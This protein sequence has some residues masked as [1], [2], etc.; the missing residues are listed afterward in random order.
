MPLSRET[1]AMRRIDTIEGVLPVTTRMVVAGL[2]AAAA[3]EAPT[4]PIVVQA[5]AVPFNVAGTLNW[6]GDTYEIE[7]GAFDVT[8]PGRVKMLLDHSRTAF[9]F[10]A[11]FHDVTKPT[12]GLMATM[13]I[14]RA[15]L[16][17]P[18]VMRAV[19]QMAN[20]IRDAVSIGARIIEADQDDGA[21]EFTS[22][23]RVTKAEL[24]EL[25]SV[26]LPMF[27]AARLDSIAAHRS[28]TKKGATKMPNATDRRARAGRDDTD[29]TDDDDTST[30]DDTD[31]NGQTE[32]ARAEAHRRAIAPRTRATAG[33]SSAPGAGRFP[34]FGAFVRANIESGVDD[35]Y[36]GRIAAAWVDELTSDVPGIV[37]ETW[38]RDVV[39]L[40]GTVSSTVDLFSTRP[41]P[42]SGNTLHQPVLTQG[43]DVGP[44]LAEKTEIASRKVLI[45]DTPFP[46]LTFAGGS[47][48]SIQTILRTDP[49]Y[50]DELMRLYARE[51]ALQLNIAATDA[52]LAG[53]TAASMPLDPADIN[54]S[55]IDAALVI[56]RATY[57]MPQVFLM[58]SNVWGAIGKAVDTDG[59]P[60]F[61]T[62]SPM[63]P[64]GSFRLTDAN[65]AVRDLGWAVD[66]SMN[67][68]SAVVG[69]RDAFRTWRGPMQTL[70]V[71]VPRL[72]GR[73]VAVF[74]FAAMG[75][76]DNR[77]LVELLLTGGV[78]PTGAQR[79]ERTERTE[80][81][82]DERTATRSTRSTSKS[83][84]S[85]S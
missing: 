61:P 42:D 10:G 2:T 82:D 34:S 72:L 49:P 70:T 79:T 32:T 56:G 4:D 48:V 20:G 45:A 25:S 84:D 62:Y 14:P 3:D 46:V 59:R 16:D 76:T 52:L 47:D 17:H 53:I 64:V 44:Q 9:G 74:E 33:A 15:E 51:M 38:I 13:H 43:P 11:E 22:H 21:D 85:G 73:D 77:G 75:V 78:A 55:I 23:Y 60:L 30:D 31:D 67:P 1:L 69:L 28:P 66:W 71:D 5:L 40:M 68:D 54:G 27:S 36:R 24:L 7:A 63:N 41:L 35:A 6:W 83:S 81:T 37:P 58:G 12:P 57:A 39:D 26:V 50:L 18:D 80:R 19:R 65:G 29:D 8:E